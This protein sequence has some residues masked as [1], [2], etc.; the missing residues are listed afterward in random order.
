MK[1]TFLLAGDRDQAY[2]AIQ[3]RR[4]PC[5]TLKTKP[6][7]IFVMGIKVLLTTFLTRIIDI[8]GNVVL[9]L[10]ILVALDFI[11]GICRAW[12]RDG[13]Q[14]ITSQ[15]L[16]KTFDKVSKYAVWIFVAMIAGNICGHDQGLPQWTRA[17]LLIL[18]RISFACVIVVE[19]ASIVENFSGRP[20]GELVVGMVAPVRVLLRAKR[21]IESDASHNDSSKNEVP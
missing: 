3:P 13:A 11:T 7:R 6:T 10:F 4:R 18:P 15:G 5:T 1:D 16:R 12:I 20:F 8:D 17:L 14:S 2:G 21:D 9:A 19:A